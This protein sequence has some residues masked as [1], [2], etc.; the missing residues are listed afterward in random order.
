MVVRAVGCLAGLRVGAGLRFV[1]F[2]VVFELL[3]AV[4]EVALHSVRAAVFVVEDEILRIPVRTWLRLVFVDFRVSSVVLKNSKSSKKSK[5]LYLKLI[6]RSLILICVLT[7][8][9]CA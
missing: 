3:P 4:A 2:G 6:D 5:I 1:H 9:L 7:C 8:Q